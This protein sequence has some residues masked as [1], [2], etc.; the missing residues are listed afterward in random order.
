MT[1]T[2][3]T[4]REVRARALDLPL[5][6]PVQTAAGDIAT[7]PVVL[8]DVVTREGVV[9]H[10]YLRTYTPV[11]LPGLARLVYDIGVFLAGESAAPHSV[12]RK[13]QGHFRLLGLEG[14]TGMA[15]A[16]IDMALWDARARAAGQPLITLLGGR[17]GP[18]PAY[19]TLPSMDAAGAAADAR[20]AVTAGFHALKVKVGRGDLAADLETIR[21][22]RAAVGDEVAL[23]VDYNQSLTVR[24]ALERVQALDAEGLHWIEEPTR[25]D[26]DAGH[27]KIAAAA[28]T[29]IQLGES[30]W[31]SAAMARSI[32]AGACDHAMLDA[33]RIGGVTGW[34]RATSL[35]VR[36]KV[37]V[38][39]HA[40][41]ELSAHLMR[42]TP[43]AHLLEYADQLNPI[44]RDRV[45]IVDGHAVF[46]EIP[47]T[48]VEWDEERIASLS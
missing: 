22:I 29:A 10:G 32:S 13:L 46:A 4:I 42:V 15:M 23:M 16:G 37:P 6:R 24:D 28:Q 20:Q 25:A 48:G 43:T 33:A 7:A 17:P 8:I 36:A 30:W 5:S 2:P 47:G 1:E 27:A 35:A 40:Y 31:G 14:L 34:L 3:L 39:S 19:V 18:V 12:E 11:A 41:P 9:G 38:S 26:D 44:L 45:R 21:A